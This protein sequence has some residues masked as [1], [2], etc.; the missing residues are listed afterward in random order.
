MITMDTIV[1]LCKRRGFIFPSSEIYG[2][3][4]GFFDYGPLGVEMRRNIKAAW[5]KEM[6]HKREDMVGLDSSI[7]MHPSVW[8][9]SGHIDGFCD[10]MVDCKESKF[11]YRADQ[12]FFA[13]VVVEGKI[14]GYVSALESEDTKGELFKKAE[15][16]KRKQGIAGK[17][18]PLSPRLFTEASPAQI[19]EIPSPATGK[20]GSLT[21]PRAFNLMFQTHVGALQDASSVAYLRPETAQGI[22]ANFKNIIDTSRVKV[23]FGIAQIG[24]A[25]RNE[26]TPRNFIFRS[27]EFEQMEIEYFIPPNEKIWPEMHQKW[28]EIRLKWHK[29]IGI[30]SELIELDIHPKEKLAHYAKA[31]TDI[32]FKFPFGTQELEGI[33]ARGNFDLSQHAKQ[34]NKSMEYFDEV[35][36]IRYIPHVIEPSV[37]VDRLFLALICAAY[38]EDVVEGQ[39]R[40]V[41]QFHPAIAPIKAGVFPLLKNKPELV[42]KAQEIYQGL[43]QY[44]NVFY[45]ATGAIGRRYRRMDEVGTPFGITIDFETLVQ[46][47]ITLRHRDSTKQERI[48]TSELKTVLEEAMQIG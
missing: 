3:I 42:K 40:V 30:P 32:A 13:S 46:D 18:E 6:V 28:L 41:L 14:L 25:F 20:P 38:K 27:R 29:Q 8:K 36:N 33:A 45:D 2:G 5:W 23:P 15:Q 44:W 7:I 12:L 24:K 48:H 4:N 31:C 37:G 47:T 43:R 39:K 21:A 17:M 35:Q 1:A 19:S 22:F 11:R 26:I 16:M 10:P 34:S 9:A